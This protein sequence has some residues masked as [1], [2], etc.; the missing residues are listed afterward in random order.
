M[1]NKKSLI[2]I[3]YTAIFT[4]MF[5]YVFAGIWNAYT[6]YEDPEGIPLV[7]M[8]LFDKMQSYEGDF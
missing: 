1:Q 2:K 3:T 6:A 4:A 8:E 5:L 7:N